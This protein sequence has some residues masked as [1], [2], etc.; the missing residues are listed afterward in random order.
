MRR[1]TSEDEQNIVDL[2]NSIPALTRGELLA[3]WEKHYGT[4]PHKLI[5]TRMLVRAVAHAVQAEQH[6]GLAKRTRKELLRMAEAAGVPA[7]AK[8]ANGHRGQVPG[9]SG[10]VGV[11]TSSRHPVR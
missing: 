3:R 4:W 11:P 1:R 8:P 6:G 7:N 10:P 5:S 2:V 9:D